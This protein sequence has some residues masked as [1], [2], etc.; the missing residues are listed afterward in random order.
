M[1]NTKTQP[2]EDA[3]KALRP[4]YSNIADCLT[5]ASHVVATHFQTVAQANNYWR[6]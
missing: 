2:V 5:M 1:A 3:R 4:V 6:D